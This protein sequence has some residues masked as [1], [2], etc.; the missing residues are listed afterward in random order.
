MPRITVTELPKELPHDEAAAEWRGG[1]DPVNRHEEKRPVR[2]EGERPGQ[3][4]EKTPVPCLYLQSI[5]VLLL[6]FRALVAPQDPGCRGGGQRPGLG[7]IDD[8]RIG[9][10]S[11]EQSLQP[12][13][14]AH[15]E[16]QLDAAAHRRR[17]SRGRNRLHQPGRRRIEGEPY[18]SVVGPGDECPERHRLLEWLRAGPGGQR[19]TGRA[20]DPPV[21]RDPGGGGGGGD[22]RRHTEGT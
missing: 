18:P 12:R 3:K 1:A 14:P 8:L 5:S 7:W 10:Q 15:E 11:E 4:T 13:L 22:R 9:A 2:I 17:L 21:G 6:L 19:T 20:L 16:L